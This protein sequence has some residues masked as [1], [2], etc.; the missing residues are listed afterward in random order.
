M[1]NRTSKLFV[2]T[3]GVVGGFTALRFLLTQ[4]T[5]QS[6]RIIMTDPYVENLAELFTA[7]KRTGVQT[8]LETN[9][10]AERAELLKRPL[11]SHRNFIDFDGLMFV[12]SHLDRQPLPHTIP[13]GTDVIIGPQA[14]RPLRVKTPLIV[15]GMAYKKALSA[16]M[17]YAFALGSSLAQTATNTGEGP[18]L[19]KE[20]ELANLL[21]VQYPRIP[22]HRDLDML[23][24]AD[25]V[26]LQIG[27]GASAGLAQA[28][29]PHLVHTALP[30]LR[31]TKDLPKVVRFLKEA[32]QGVP[33]GVKFSFTNNLEREI[34]LCLEAGVDFLALEGAQAAAVGAA[35]I[36]ED[37]FG[38]PTIMGLCRAV[39]HLQQRGVHNKVSLIVSGGFFSP[40]QCLK[41]L[42]LGANAVYLGT[43][44]LYA[45]S[46][47]QTLKTLPWEPP[48]QIAVKGGKLSKKYNWKL[49]GKHLANYLISCTEEIKEGVRALGKHALD[50]VDSSDLV[51]LDEVTSKITGIP[52]A[53]PNR[54]VRVFSSVEG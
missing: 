17:K 51:A 50:Q 20:R 6:L 22:I 52:L 36:L 3:L 10:R 5:R 40:G 9:L 41:A 25:A 53:Y 47:T 27:Q 34:D 2:G 16:K 14:K 38:L 1:S 43:M 48:T 46:H 42:A 19:P 21:I 24:Q 8:I 44:S 45:A 31:E 13:V 26:E 29:F 33:V 32:G 54:K 35:P 18:W 49:G 23:T 37:D 12:S 4:V 39:E 30:A 7:T 15:S 28:P 11:G